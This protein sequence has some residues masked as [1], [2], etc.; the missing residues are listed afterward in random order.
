MSER[1]EQTAPPRRSPH[2]PR[3]GVPVPSLDPGSPT[4]HWRKHPSD[5]H[6][7]CATGELIAAGQE[8]DS[9]MRDHKMRVAEVH[10]LLSVRDA[11][12]ETTATLREVV[13]SSIETNAELSQTI[14][15]ATKAVVVEMRKATVK[16]VANGDSEAA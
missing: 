3:E 8:A 15:T 6:A 7:D 16:P 14:K 10:A 13:G 12:L 5:Y 2:P 9:I 4:E 1:V 11:L